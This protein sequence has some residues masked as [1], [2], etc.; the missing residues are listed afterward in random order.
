MNIHHTKLRNS[1][2]T[3][4]VEKL[5]YISMNTRVLGDIGWPDTLINDTQLNQLRQQQKAVD[6]GD[7]DQR[8]SIDAGF[9]RLDLRY[10]RS[11][12]TGRWCFERYHTCD[13]P[14]TVGLDKGSV[15]FRRW[16][17]ARF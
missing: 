13:G 7:F 12:P 4:Q 16:L 2:K 6:E 15:H 5:I 10:T 17:F 11:V 1:L 14:T 8:T 3:P 9:E